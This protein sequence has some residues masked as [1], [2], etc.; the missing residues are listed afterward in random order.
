MASAAVNAQVGPKLGLYSAPTL[1]WPE[2]ATQTFKR[3]SV[4]AVD[5]NGRAAEAGANPG[6]I[7]GI[8]AN[9]GQ[10][11][12]T[13]GTPNSSAPGNVTGETTITPA[14]PQVQFEMNLDDGSNYALLQTDLGK[15]YGITKDSSTG[16]WY[17]DQTKTAGNARV[18]IV[19]FK[20]AVGTACARVY[21]VFKAGSTIYQ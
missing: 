12:T 4:I 13:A 6:Q 16:V 17:V 14:L 19:G 9:Q 5:G 21:V 8:A 10:N 2:A 15:A 11:L 1:S 20:D 7:V 3:G 18:I